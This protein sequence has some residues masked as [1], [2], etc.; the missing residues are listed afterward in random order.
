MTDGYELYTYDYH[1]LN[2]NQIE[3]QM[4][5]SYKIILYIYATKNL[6]PYTITNLE[7]W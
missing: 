4:K 3:A 1:E 6:C 5:K 7:F 2:Y